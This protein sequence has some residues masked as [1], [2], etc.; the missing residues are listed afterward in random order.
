VEQKNMLNRVD[1]HNNEELHIQ[2]QSHENKS[3]LIELNKDCTKLDLVV[4]CLEHA[5]SACELNINMVLKQDA[6]CQMGVLDLEKSPL[7]WNHFVDLQEEGAE[8]EILSGQLCQEHIEKVCDMEVRHNAP[9][10]N[11]QMKNFAVL[12]DYGQYQMVADG[13]IKKG[14]FDAQSHQATR[15]LTLGQ[16]HKTK[17]IPLLLIDE[18]DVK[19]SHALTIG[20]PDAD[21]LY[22]L[23]SRGL[24]TKQAVGLLSVGYF[25]PVIDMVED[26]ELKENLRQEMESKVG[27]YG[28]Q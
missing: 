24:S 2:I 15:V 9:H 13:N 27:L 16:G 6:S 18:N 14:C 26:E 5:E 3:Y 1:V 23:Q 11:G 25:L 22:Y 12:F 21:Q 20:Q 10:T 4:E 28:H 19:A 8:Y 17:V 7:K